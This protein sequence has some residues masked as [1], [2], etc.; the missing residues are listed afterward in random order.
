[1]IKGFYAAAS[2]MLAGVYRQQTLAHNI[3]NM[4]TPG[5]KQ[6]LTSLDDFKQTP[7]LAANGKLLGSRPLYLGNL[8]L[9]VEGAPDTTDF[10]QGGILNTGHSLDLALEGDG[11]FRVKAPE[12]ERYTR[13]GRFIRDAA[14][15]LVTV[16]GFQVLD[17]GGQPIE[18]E[19]GEV[20]IDPDGAIWVNGSETGRLSLAVFKEPLTELVR[21]GDNTF[22]AAG[23]PAGEFTGAV[24]QG[25]L[26][27][28]NA[29]ATYLMTQLV[30]VLRTYQA[31]QQMVQNQDELL[32][33]TIASLG[34]IG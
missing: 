29:N 5:F 24:R 6:I 14:G 22:S 17:E 34:R 20:R 27:A 25:A 1:M 26:E 23:G 2:A 30:E 7:V 16:T 12:G 13:D 11:F 18:L 4:D 21:E 8:G 32:G 9:G 31:A 3:A 28:S 10:G 19:D 33:R 15:Q